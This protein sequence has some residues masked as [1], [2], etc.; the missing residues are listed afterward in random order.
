MKEPNLQVNELLYALL[1]G[2]F[3]RASN[4]EMEGFAGCEGEGWIWSYQYGFVIID[5]MED[6]MIAQVFEMDIDT[7]S[8]HV[9]AFNPE[10]RCFE[11]LH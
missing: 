1:E 7:D 5:F 2:K 4:S 6:H 11:Q 8:D 10:D 9:W 3:H